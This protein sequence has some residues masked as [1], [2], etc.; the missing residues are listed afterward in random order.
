MPKNLHWLTQIEVE[1]L[2][3]ALKSGITAEIL[4]LFPQEFQ[5][6]K[7]PRWKRGDEPL[8]RRML[9]AKK[10]GS[11]ITLKAES[12]KTKNKRAKCKVT[13]KKLPMKKRVVTPPPTDP[14]PTQETSPPEQQKPK[15]T[16]TPPADTSVLEPVT[17]SMHDH[18]VPDGQTMSTEKKF[19][20][21][22]DSDLDIL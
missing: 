13:A 6:G 14:A 1:V 4:P 21:I 11:K 19:L 3:N 22:H 10:S 2:E 8:I 9:C 16:S 7:I 18:M 5:D 12:S 17:P 15:R 20:P